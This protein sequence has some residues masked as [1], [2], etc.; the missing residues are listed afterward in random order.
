MVT[1]HITFYC[2]G[3]CAFHIIALE[4][5]NLFWNVCAFEASSSLFPK[6]RGILLLV[7]HVFSGCSCVRVPE[8]LLKFLW[9]TWWCFPSLLWLLSLLVIC[10]STSSAFW[11]ISAVLPHQPLCG[12]QDEVTR[13]CESACRHFN[14]IFFCRISQLTLCLHCPLQPPYFHFERTRC[15]EQH[16]INI[17]AAAVCRQRASFLSHCVAK[18][19]HTLPVPPHD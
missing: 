14:I 16:G 18:V 5:R 1:A 2:C 19:S 6:P 15:S 10:T 8:L 11:A 12:T 4:T 17:S 3:S 9:E 13:V 7:L